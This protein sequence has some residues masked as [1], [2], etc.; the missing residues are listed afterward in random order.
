M[1][2][3]DIWRVEIKHLLFLQ[4]KENL[5]ALL[6]KNNISIVFMES[7][8]EEHRHPVRHIKVSLQVIT[9]DKLNQITFN[10]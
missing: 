9:A 6:T 5:M 1:T 3:R 4:T 7:F 10:S 8:E 2:F